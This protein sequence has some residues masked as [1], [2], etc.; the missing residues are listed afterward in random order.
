MTLKDLR[1]ES[2]LKARKVAE[3]L[4]ISREHLYNLE[5]GKYKLDKLKLEKLCEVY[6]KGADEILSI[7]SV[8]EKEGVNYD[9]K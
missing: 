3:Y 2:G 9:R 6:C 7:S 1:I 4:G 8:K 5:K